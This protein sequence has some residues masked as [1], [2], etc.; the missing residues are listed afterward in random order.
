M[1]KGNALPLNG[2]ANGTVDIRSAAAGTVPRLLEKR[3]LSFG[4]AEER[5]VPTLAKIYPEAW[6]KEKFL[7]ALGLDDEQIREVRRAFELREGQL[8]AAMRNFREGQIV[9]F[10]D[11]TAV[12]M[13]NTLL[14]PVNSLEDVSGGYAQ[15]TG[16][17]TL[18]THV[19]LKHAREQGKAVLLY[20]VS[21]IVDPK[22]EE[23]DF[24]FQTLNHAVTT[25][26]EMGVIPCPYSAP[27]GYALQK[28]VLEQTGVP[29]V[30]ND[31]LHFTR[32]REGKG[33]RLITYEQYL[34]RVERLAR[35]P[36]IQALYRDGFE[37]LAIQ[38]FK[39]EIGKLESRAPIAADENG[40]TR[41]TLFSEFKREY[42]RWFREKHGRGMT[43]ED[44]CWL[45]GRKLADPV[46]GLHVDNGAAYIRDAQGRIACVFEGSRPED[47]V[48]DGYNVVLTYGF[49]PLLFENLRV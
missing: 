38:D 35:K 15:V 3:V 22:F 47:V 36:L 24:A 34:Q 12:T 45:T 33:G 39:A 41:E 11:G 1:S 49:D 6:V 14:H 16:D 30:M 9:G 43:V 32:P 2:R 27:R 29:L 18:S 46:L 31:Y 44:Y 21:V 37:P 10:L 25:A 8:K 13:I 7:R 42:G 48:S 28:K 20:C 4:P 19:P 40:L 26:L 23:T 5:D 17:K